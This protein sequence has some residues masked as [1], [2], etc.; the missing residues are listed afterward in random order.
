MDPSQRIRLSTRAII[1][2][3][4]GQTDIIMAELNAKLPALAQELGLVLKPLTPNWSPCKCPE[5][6]LL[7]TRDESR[8]GWVCP[9][10]GCDAEF[11]WGGEQV[12]P[13]VEAVFAEEAR[14]PHKSGGGAKGRRRK[15]PPKPRQGE[16]ALR[17]N[18]KP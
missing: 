10:P 15:K 8:R 1:A 18:L 11:R 16:N 13:A 9:V 4:Q 12:D 17:V 6:G 7:L 3:C 14:R 5:H 2:W